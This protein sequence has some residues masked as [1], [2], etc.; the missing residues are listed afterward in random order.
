M[1]ETSLAV[2]KDL[3]GSLK[4]TLKA[5]LL[6]MHTD[7]EGARILKEFGAQRFIE[8]KD[9]DFK[10]VYEYA[11]NIGLDLRTWDTTTQSR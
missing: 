5:A 1:P 8:T 2:R 9:S 6:N 4:E 11:R 3:D 10:P 7:P